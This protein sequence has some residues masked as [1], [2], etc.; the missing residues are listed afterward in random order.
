[1]RLE[2]WKAATAVSSLGSDRG[3]AFGDEL[4][5]SVEAKECG[6][7][8]GMWNVGCGM[9]AGE[10][11]RQPC[12]FYFYLSIVEQEKLSSIFALRPAWG[13]GVC[14][15][16]KAVESLMGPSHCPGA[17][18][19]VDFATSLRRLAPHGLVAYPPLETLR[20]DS[21]VQA[22]LP[23]GTKTYDGI[24]ANGSYS[25][26]S[27]S[28]PS[29]PS[30]AQLASSHGGKIR[31]DH[32]MMFEHFT[33]GAQ[34]Q[35]RLEEDVSASP[36]DTSF[37]S[38]LEPAPTSGFGDFSHNKSQSGISEI[39]HRLSQQNLRQAE[40]D[41]PVASWECSV[42]SPPREQDEEM[43]IVTRI[44]DYQSVPSTP[45]LSSPR[46]SNV[47][48]RRLQRQLNAQLHNCNSHVRDINTLVEEMIA[49]NSQCTLHSSTQDLSLPPV[50][51]WQLGMGI[52]VDTRIFAERHITPEEDEGFGE[53]EEWSVEDE[54]TLR[55]ASAPT[56]I[57]KL[58][59][60]RWR[61]S[62]DCVTTREKVRS[63]PRMRKRKHHKLSEQRV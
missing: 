13:F 58:N 44:S 47:A 43:A 51:S 7:G 55:R 45:I 49:T 24:H 5:F 39:V 53:P 9:L 62:A 54:M 19:R 15:L 52:K 36:T 59:T 28:L 50:T 12:T 21:V 56:G 11:R 42:P 46:S 1:M 25:V 61:T 18:R 6:K 16:P 63:V 14:V 20:D 38:P 10:C 8:G 4:E 33:F 22:T 35:T 31:K 41:I 60:F 26:S 34:A 32:F 27:I 48:C 29:T 57:K 23:P 2:C 17:N 37:S 40:Q 30:L 3:R